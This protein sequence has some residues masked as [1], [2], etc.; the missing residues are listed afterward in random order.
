MVLVPA[1][2]YPNGAIFSQNL[3]LLRLAKRLPTVPMR[4]HYPSSGNCADDVVP[5][6]LTIGASNGV[7]LNK[8][9]VLGLDGV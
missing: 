3:A 5:D 2:P 9:Y 7:A 6:F 1:L 4:C 8:S